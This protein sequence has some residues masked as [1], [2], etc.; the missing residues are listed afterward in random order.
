MEGFGLTDDTSRYVL[1]SD[2]GHFDNLGLYEMVLRRCRFIVVVDA[3]QDENATF[4]DIGATVR[5]IRIDLG[6]DIVFERPVAIYKKGHPEIEKG[7]GR[8]CAVATIRYPDGDGDPRGVLLYIKPGILGDEPRDVIQYAIANPAFPH[9]S[10][11]D[12]LFDES[13]FES[14][15]RLGE[16]VVDS[17]CG[18]PVSSNM[19]LRGFVDGLYKAHL[20]RE[21]RR[22]VLSLVDGL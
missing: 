15:R 19:T 17:L 22:E 3:S 16:H 10:T 8:Y 9:Q 5:K 2:G 14:Y 6:I 1:L 11:L 12:Q 18:A 7:N 20:K 21:P 13:Q 4:D